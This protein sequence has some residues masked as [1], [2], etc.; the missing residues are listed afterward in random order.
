M[1]SAGVPITKELVLLGGGHSHVEVLR[2]FGMKPVPGTRL[3]LVTR[4]VH[5]PYRCRQITFKFQLLPY[6]VPC[7]KCT[8]CSGEESVW[9]C[10]VEPC[11]A[12]AHKRVQ[13]GRLCEMKETAVQLWNFFFPFMVVFCSGMLPG[14]VS[15]F[16]EYD[17]CHIDLR[18]LAAFAGA[19]FLH[20]EASGIDLASRRLMLSGRPHLQYDVL[21]INT[22]ITPDQESVP[23]AREY[24][25]AVKPVNSFI[26]RFHQVLAKVQRAGR[27]LTIAVVGGGAGG[28]EL[29]LAVRHRLEDMRIHAGKPKEASAK[30][31]LVTRGKILATHIAYVRRTF[32]KVLEDKGVAL[33]EDATV[34]RVS[35]GELLLVDGSS[36]TFDV[37]LWCTDASAASWT[38]L[39][40]LKT[41][42]KGFLLVNDYLQAD[43]GPPEVF[44]AGDVATNRNHPRPKAGVFAVRQGAPLAVNLKHFLQNKPLVPFTPQST[45]LSLISTGEKYCVA[46]KGW[47]G[48]QGAW[49]WTV[50]DYIDR[51]FMTKYGT[52]LPSMG[53]RGPVVQDKSVGVNG[54]AQVLAEAAMRCAG[55]GGKVG[56][57]VL[58][59]ALSAAVRLGSSSVVVPGYEPLDD[60]AVIKPPPPG[61]VLL[62][63]VD[64]LR[65]CVDD[66]YLFGVITANHCLSVSVS[67]PSQLSSAFAKIRYRNV[68]EPSRRLR[69]RFDVQHKFKKVHFVPLPVMLLFCASELPGG[70]SKSADSPVINLQPT[71]SDHMTIPLQRCGYIITSEHDNCK[72]MGP[73]FPLQAKQGFGVLQVARLR[74]E[75]ARVTS[76]LAELDM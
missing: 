1:L 41:D 12:A 63:T 51:Q 6:V 43:D 62:Q 25:T 14:Y 69:T 56:R 58:T 17:E 19:R 46:S 26:D 31:R 64:F 13:G 11:G 29:A 9:L 15:G 42:D 50:K 10:L 55:C 37:C 2:S 27:A 28:V 7:G 75:S 72:N 30:I 35:E 21:S 16:Y 3:T 66:P 44:A 73:A 8:C 39:T 22:G 68:L 53:N 18:Q 71:S 32:L 48:A 36:I 61:H 49:L 70:G 33:S 76:S 59:T 54:D 23:G 74:M 65:S 38:K 24:T 67:P 4:D 34:E 20:A 57:G 47:F 45:F 5:T 52:G 60:A 40:G